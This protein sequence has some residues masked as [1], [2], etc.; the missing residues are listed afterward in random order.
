LDAD[1]PAGALPLHSRPEWQG[2][3]AAIERAAQTVPKH[4]LY[5]WIF[6]SLVPHAGRRNGV[7]CFRVLPVVSI[8]Q[9]VEKFFA[10]VA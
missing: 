10:L 6:D 4:S 3:L 1:Q 2:L 8:L 5:Q 9:R 7:H